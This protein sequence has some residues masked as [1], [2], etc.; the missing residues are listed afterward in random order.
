[1]TVLNTFPPLQAAIAHAESWRTYLNACQDEL[2]S[3]HGQ[4]IVAKAE[5]TV[6]IGVQLGELLPITWR[7]AFHVFFRPSLASWNSAKEFEAFRQEVRALFYTVRE[8]LDESRKTAEMLQTLTGRQPV[9]MD[10][11]LKV[12]EEARELEE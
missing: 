4:E 9:R 11:L 2:R 12:I 7:A 8:A 1:M 3:P 5:N 6:S 10:R